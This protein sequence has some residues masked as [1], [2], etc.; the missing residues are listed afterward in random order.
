MKKFGNL[1]WGLV[2]IAI[3]LV[4]IL[5]ALGIADINIFF[6]GWWTLFIIVPCFISLFT[7]N[8]KTG[9]LIG[10]LI[11]AVLLLVAQDVIEFVTIW[12]LLLPTIFIIIG[13]SII[14]S[15]AIQSKISEKIKSLSKDGLEN[16]A[17]TFGG[18]K[19][20]MAAGEFKGANIDAVFGGVE[21]D[22]RDSTISKEQIINANA[23]FGGI[24]I[25]APQGVI[26]KV[27]STPIFGGVSNKT[28]QP[29][30]DNAPILYINAFCLF[31]GVEIK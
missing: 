30:F 26:V 15:S 3:G 1:L 6:R 25:I 19:V 4:W 24:E 18:Q 31:G 28:R 21:F 9:S 20:N 2:F 17:A 8:N 22:M 7:D 13:L 11:G 16:Y 12:K 23:I 27:K 14:F 5:N 29:N 10:L